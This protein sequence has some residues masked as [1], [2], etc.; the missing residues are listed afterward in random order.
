M[1]EHLGFAG[2]PQLL[3]LASLGS[4]RHCTFRAGTL[5]SGVQQSAPVG[6]GPFH[7]S[8]ACSLPCAGALFGLC[9]TRLHLAFAA[10]G[11]EGPMAASNQIHT[12]V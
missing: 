12:A 4:S 11:L 1:S 7:H 10:A 6:G 3:A 5:R 2:F 8:V 9:S